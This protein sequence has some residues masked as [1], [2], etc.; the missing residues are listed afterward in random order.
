MSILEPLNFIIVALTNNI[1]HSIK[2]KPV[3]TAV[4]QILPAELK[5]FEKLHSQWVSE[6]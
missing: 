2:H 3:A 6:S 5:D 4:G 1:H